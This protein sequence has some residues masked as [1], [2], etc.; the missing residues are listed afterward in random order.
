[1]LTNYLLIVKVSVDANLT[2]FNGHEIGDNIKRI[3]LMY[4]LVDDVVV[5]LNPTQYHPQKEYFK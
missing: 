3:L 4:E 1:M 5:H 2:I